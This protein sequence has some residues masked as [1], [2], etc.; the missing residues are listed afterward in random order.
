[1]LQK[2]LFRLNF[3]SKSS[4][5]SGKP[6]A[7]PQT[8]SKQLLTSEKPGGL[9]LKTQLCQHSQTITYSSGSASHFIEENPGKYNAGNQLTSLTLLAASAEFLY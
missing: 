5:F 7:R 9:S 2:L 4:S 8:P 6:S 3:P 1:M